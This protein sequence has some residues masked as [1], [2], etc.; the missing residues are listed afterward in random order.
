QYSM[1]TTVVT[2]TL[3]LLLAAAATA[4]A[5]K[6]FPSIG[7]GGHLTRAGAHSVHQRTSEH[8][9]HDQET[10]DLW[11]VL[12]ASKRILDYYKAHMTDMNM[13]AVI[14]TRMAE[15]QYVVLVEALTAGTLIPR[16]RV[17]V[18]VLRELLDSTRTFNIKAS[19]YIRNAYPEYFKALGRLLEPGFWEIPLRFRHLDNSTSASYEFDNLRVLQGVEQLHEDQSDTCITEVL[20][21]EQKQGSSQETKGKAGDQL[22]HHEHIRSDDYFLNEFARRLRQSLGDDGFIEEEKCLISGWCWSTMT[23]RGYSGY[24]LTHELFYLIIALQAGC[25]NQIEDIISSN[26]REPL[27]DIVKGLCDNVLREAQ[28]IADAKYPEMRRDLFMEQGALCGMVGYVDFF[29]RSWLHH[30]L[31]WQR[32]SGCYGNSVIYQSLKK[33]IDAV[34]RIKRD[35]KS[36]PGQCLAHRSATAIGYLA[37]ALRRLIFL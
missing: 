25:G 32:E 22:G 7:G 11:D 28:A 17:A 6:L 20:T 9:P 2:T 16:D 31:S 18:E 23:G 13:D 10:Q 33:P 26:G 4:A 3:P 35:E 14:G 34:N 8:R 29:P 36:M 12:S 19:H 1:R 5:L 21:G 27:E 30:V 15:G 37:L 24:S